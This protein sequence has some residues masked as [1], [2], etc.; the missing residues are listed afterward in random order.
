VEQTAPD[1]RLSGRQQFE[2]DGQQVIEK[3]LGAQ[4]I[5][6]GK[7]LDRRLPR[8]SHDVRRD[9]SQTASVELGGLLMGQRRTRRVLTVPETEALAMIATEQRSSGKAALSPVAD[10]QEP[11]NQFGRNLPRSR[12][13][14]CS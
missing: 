11:L 1:C 7:T 9:V 12:P 2:A 8:R 6:R 13:D 5:V 3:G 10:S 4:R 14:N